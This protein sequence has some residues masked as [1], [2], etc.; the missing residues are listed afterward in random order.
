MK[1]S[2]SSLILVCL[3]AFVAM[4]QSRLAEITEPVTTEFGVYQPLLVTV[5]PDAPVCDP[6]VNLEKVENLSAFDLSEEAISLLKK[7]HFCVTPNTRPPYMSSSTGFNELF[8]LYCE[9]RE[10]GVPNFITSDALLHTF[11]LCFDYILKTCE[12]KRFIQQLNLLLNGLLSETMQQI[13]AANADSMRSALNM[14]LD[15]L[16]VAK[17]LLDS[18]YVEPINGGA[19]L[20]E[21]T[22]VQNAEGFINSPI[23]KYDEDYS[24]YIVRG[25]YT[26]SAELRRYFQSMMWLGRMTFSCERVDDP[27][28]R[29]ATR[30]ALALLQAFQCARINGQSAMTVWDEIY[31]PTVFFVGKSDD[32][33]VLN[34]LPLIEQVYGANF[35]VQSPDL[36][37][38]PALL[39]QFLLL[40][41]E[42]AEAAIQYPGQPTKGFRFMGQRFIPDSWVL[43][44]LVFPQV[45]ARFMPTGLDVMQA[46]GSERAFALL[47]LKDQ[48]DADYVKQMEKVKQ[49]FNGYTA[50]KW[51]Q[52][53]Y[54][55]WLYSLMPLLWSKGEGYPWFM[56]TT[57]WQDKDL[58]AALASWAELRHDTIL[59]AK[60]SGT[61][62]NMPV[63]AGMVQ[64]Y[65]EPNAH[66]F[67]RMAALAKFMQQGLNN[68][69]LLFTEFKTTL[70]L[71]HDTAIQ[72]K[73]IAEKELIATPLSGDD[74]AFIFDFGIT[75]FKIATMC[76]PGLT[77]PSS[78][79]YTP[80]SMLEPMPVVADVHTDANSGT[81]LEEGVGYPYAIYVVCNIEGRPMIT[82]GAG[83][84]YHEFTRPLNE[85]MT[86][87]QWRSRQTSN[88]PQQP[89]DWCKSFVA[90]L[91][92]YNPL[93]T[94]F[95]WK[96]L[97][98]WHCVADFDSSQQTLDEGDTLQLAIRTSMYDHINP[99]KVEIVKQDQIWQIDDVRTVP[100]SWPVEFASS[101]DTG[102]LLPGVYYLIIT[103]PVSGD[104]LKYRTH[105]TITGQ[106]GVEGKPT[107]VHAY[108]L[109]ANWPNPF[110]PNTTIGYALA[111]DQDVVVEIYNTKGQ[112]VKS[113][114]SG[115]QTA[116]P[117]ELHWDG[118]DDNQRLLSSGVYF[119]R[120]Q[121]RDLKQIRPISL[122]K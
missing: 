20:Q 27:F 87:E 15:Y 104:T 88:S 111:S 25:H 10:H 90:D 73:N 115:W 68:R 50:E 102:A 97:D 14:N 55:N 17:K 35:A 84:S 51:A 108:Q 118:T 105:F 24:Q 19:Y 1:S 46:L 65:V 121:G 3:A 116:G 63:A 28:S 96:K 81:V 89:V 60:Q 2:S 56:Q 86:D 91:P 83:F 12:E 29:A 31:Q 74:Y 13:S 41:E 5:K 107:P 103:L 40:T 38:D 11:H 114:H 59:Y 61:K 64:G 117:H 109:L 79:F 57:A 4:G 100:E 34:Y 66:F 7:N 22:L 106:T 58:F 72:L 21:L 75:L 99:P 42:L 53:L 9:N 77:G 62:T 30:S 49:E 43:G 94:F 82:R 52:N 92:E 101:F 95:L 44:Q 69:N 80:G 33:N 93:P 71:F 119:I 8:D 37:A 26:R 70:T 110:N 98:S 113:L 45:P 120:L 122:I 85:R 32:I 6:G 16:I 39:T 23:F 18:T 67:A 54:W 47:P 112:K 78:P 48:N 76:V 36:F